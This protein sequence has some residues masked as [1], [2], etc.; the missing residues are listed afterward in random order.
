V[1][2]LANGDYSI[3]VVSSSKC[4]QVVL[5]VIGSPSALAA[6]SNVTLRAVETHLLLDTTAI[7]SYNPHLRVEPPLGQ[8]S[9]RLA[10]I[11]GIKSGVIDA[12][13]IDHTPYTYEEKTVPF[14][15][16][17]PGA[18]GLELAL[19]LLWQHLVETQA[20]TGL[21]LWQALSTRPSQCLGQAPAAIAAGQAAELTLFDPQQPA[22]PSKSLSKNTPWQGN[23][24]G[25]VVQ[26]WCER[27]SAGFQFASRDPKR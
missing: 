4:I 24:T 5:A 19:P 21:E 17:P 6:A 22:T 27:S 20:L 11:E 3:A 25:Q 26:T 23:L 12:I 18:I 8:P 10:L 14:A 7:A 15:E 9:D 16:A 1:A 13:A 2:R